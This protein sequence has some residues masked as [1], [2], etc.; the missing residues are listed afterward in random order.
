MATVTSNQETVVTTIAC[1][2][3][4]PKA[5]YLA[6]TA[7]THHPEWKFVLCLL[8]RKLHPAIAEV[9]VFDTVVLA[10]ELQHPN[11]E[12]FIFKHTV[13]EAA[14]AVKAM[15]LR[16]LMRR[17]SKKSRFIY[18]DADIWINSRFEELDRIK[19]FNVLVTP[20]H[21]QDEESPEAIRDNVFRTLQC[22]IFNLGFLVLHRTQ[23]AD[24]FLQWWES[25][26]KLFCYVDYS[27]GLFAD[28]KWIDLAVVFFDLT[29]LKHPGYNVA[30]WNISKRK[31]IYREGR[32]EVN[33]E[34]L[35][36]LHF[37]GIDSGGDLRIFRRYAPNPHDAIHQLRREYKH[38]VNSLGY[39]RLQ[40]EAWSYDYFISGEKISFA[41][42]IACRNNPSLLAQY[43]NPFECS[44]EAFTSVG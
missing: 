32:L 1:A 44:N 42:R 20:H 10:C 2:N 34:P 23:E 35:R 33:G 21:L 22:G 15:L 41:A 5:I 19:P 27:R 3:Y 11:F 31:V 17:F 43:A 36:F 16:Y 8:E 39:D 4:L 25:R 13:T 29:I 12:A 26:L 14:S 6:K 9:G 18:L 24:R 28:Q 38:A 37:S 40:F 30:N 7:R